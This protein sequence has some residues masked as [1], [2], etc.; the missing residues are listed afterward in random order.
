MATFV[1]AP[2]FTRGLPR[3][4]GRLQALGAAGAV[5]TYCYRTSA[6]ARG[7]TT[8]LGAIPAGAE[9]ERTVTT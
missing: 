7:N 4:R 2:T 1:S 6:G 8:D 3:V 9:I 5:V